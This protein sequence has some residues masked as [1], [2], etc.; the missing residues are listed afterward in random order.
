MRTALAGSVQRC[1]TD[2]QLT[3]VYPSTVI[4]LPVFPEL[5]NA[6]RTHALALIVLP[7]INTAGISQMPAHCKLPLALAFAAAADVM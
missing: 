6:T 4:S 1:S 2:P 5:T 3:D 7:C